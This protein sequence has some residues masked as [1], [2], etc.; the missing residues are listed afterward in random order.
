MTT[1]ETRIQSHGTAIAR[2][3]K[4][5][6]K[7][8]SFFVFFSLMGPSRS[9][10]KLH[11]HA[12]TTGLKIS[13]GQLKRYSIK[14]RWQERLAEDAEMVREKMVDARVESSVAMNMR[15]AQLGTAL[16]GLGA[17]GVQSLT[18]RVDQ[19]SF[20]DAGGL[21]ERGV[22]VER[23]AMGEATDRHE[24]TVEIVEPLVHRIV[25]LFQEVNVVEDAN[26]RMR[27]FGFGADA[28]LRDTFGADEIGGR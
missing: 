2:E 13:L 6:A 16:Q 11:Y 14:Y 5:E 8:E 4:Q 28:I 17:R 19:M 24:L 7:A 9:L 22:R 23:L 12:T 15:Q 1:K 21:I 10:E 27:D 20:S 25:A 18:G 26:K 3:V